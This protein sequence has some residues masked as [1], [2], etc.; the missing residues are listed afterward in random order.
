M[1]EGK[2]I[3]YYSGT[4]GTKSAAMSTYEKEALATLEALKRWRHYFLGG[5]LRIK[6]NQ[7]SLK[8]ITE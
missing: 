1:Q 7:K 6:T 2:P 4:L 8:F 3:A 5:E